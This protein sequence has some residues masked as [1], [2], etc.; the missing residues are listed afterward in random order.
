[1]Q[2]LRKIALVIAETLCLPLSITYTLFLSIEN[3]RSR[4]RMNS[5]LDQMRSVSEILT[6][7][8]QE[9]HASHG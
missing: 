7:Q 1:M 2:N 3:H 4:E 9:N 8:R 5:Q 6:S